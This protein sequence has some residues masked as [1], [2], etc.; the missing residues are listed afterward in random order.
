MLTRNEVEHN[1]H[2]VYYR[3]PRGAAEAGS[4]VRL[5]L[6]IRSRQQINQVLLH[7][8]QDKI[9]EKLLPLVTK[10]PLDADHRY[11]YIDYEMPPKGDL[12]WY[13]FIISCSDGTCY[14][15]N[16]REQWGGPGDVY[17]HVPPAYQITV[18]NKGA[19]T[20]DWFKHAVM[21]QIFPDRFYRQGDKLIEKEGAV[22]HA[23]WT[24]DPC[25]YK[26]PDTKEIVSYDFFGGN[27]A[28]LMAKLDYLKELGISVIYLNP[29]FESES[30][31]HYDTGD[32]HKIDP[33]LGTNAEF[34]EFVEQAAKKGIRVI[35]D[36]VFSHT[37]SN[38]RYFNRKGKYD[39]VGAFQSEKSPYYEWY[40]FRNFPYEYDCWWDFNTLPNVRETTPSYMD[41]IIRKPDSVLHHWLKEGIAGWRLD[42]I[43]ELPE[44]FSQSFYAELKKTNKD[45][46]M[47]GEVWED[48]SNKVAYGTPRKYLCGQE[49]DSAMN[50]P[51]RKILLD[52][53]LGYVTGHNTMRQL[54]SLRENYPPEN[55]YAMMNLIGSHDVQRAITVLGETPY[56]DGMPAVEQCRARLSPE[57]YKVGKSRLK[58]AALFQMTYPGVPCIYYGDEIGMEGFKDPTNRRPYKWQGGDE[59]LREFYHT[60]IRARNEN[61]ALQTGELLSLT[62]EGDILA[63]ARVVRSGHDVFGMDAANGAFI[64]I[65]N[66]SRTDSHTVHLDISDFADGQFVDMVP[67]EGRKEELLLSHRGKLDVKMPPL[68]GRLLRYKPL[69]RK[70]EREAGILLH[71]TSLPSKY[72]IGDLG[73]EAYKFVDFL[74]AAGLKVWQILP[75]GPVG[76]GF[77]PY[78]SPSA[79]AGNPLLI[80]VDELLEHGWITPAEARVPYASKSSFIDFERVISFK[81]KCFKKAWIAFQKSKDVEIKGEYQA[82]I[83]EAASWLDDYALFDA[84]K[85]EYK[86]KPWF[87]WPEP[88]VRRE[89]K[90]L[91][92]LAEHMEE[93]VGYAKFV[94]FLF[95]RQWNKLHEYAG[96][97]GIKIMGDMPIFISHDSADVWANQKLFDLNPDGS[98]KTVAGVPPDYFSATGQL[99]GNPQYD[100][101]AMEQEDYTWWKKRFV[102]LHR[103]VDIVRID[104]FRGFESYWE[105]DG[106]AE[107]AINGHWRKGPGKPFFDIIKKEIG[108]ME[109]VAED[110]GIIT[111]EVEALREACGFP[112][113]KVLHFALH[114]NE[115]GRMGFVASENSIVYTGTHDNNTTV[116]WYNQDLDDAAR[117]SV[118]ALV[119]AKLDR[120]WDVAKGLMKFALASEARLAIAPM[121]DV[122]GLDERAR[123]NTPGTVGLNWKWCLKPDYLLG[124]DIEAIKKLCEKYGRC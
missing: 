60:I 40:S 54:N 25:Y 102:N 124:I 116:G 56:Y 76:F 93:A 20:P 3:S 66:R 84:A 65:F 83:E 67:M 39:G 51:F 86:N 99:W 122:L 18:Y 45:A 1:S 5:G 4:K 120:P 31:H 88:I 59:E 91:K 36:G 62:A 103:L 82:F 74:A 23:S 58:M 101:E 43:D 28:G 8:W 104:H 13:Y 109:I 87:E 111:D 26:D 30:N 108:D 10:D 34:H 94:Q 115:Q 70:Y 80:D 77:S 35:L 110:L 63:F 79:F 7:V 16:N 105:V 81:H 85:K 119:G 57:M 37:G 112:G 32:Y 96:S 42:V 72:G 97:K 14:Y 61:D 71:P 15:G 78:Q 92:K 6:Q 33:I 24:D 17:T 114:F 113:M 22:Y 11:Y 21:Y 2:N 41:F 38:S 121:Q 69:P 12:L 50:Y 117:A 52:Y 44:P 118:A 27:L 55:F 100:W 123:M 29:V 73:K 68:S 53:L 19:K 106:K 9:G 46:V 75:L 47:I 95:H 98:A 90:A 48:A 107:T 89:P 64:T 49:M